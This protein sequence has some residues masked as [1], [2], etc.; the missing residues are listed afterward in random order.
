V[1]V[2]GGVPSA[3]SR[4]GGVQPTIHDNVKD[5]VSNKARW[6][7][8]GSS[9]RLFCWKPLVVARF[10]M[11]LSLKNDSLE[12]ERVVCGYHRMRAW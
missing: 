12:H 8:L 4:V 9:L 5:N 2:A 11:A 7:I 3:A 1:D 10:F 6:A